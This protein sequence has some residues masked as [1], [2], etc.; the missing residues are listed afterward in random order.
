M[1][2]RLYLRPLFP[3]PLSLLELGVRTD[4]YSL[5]SRKTASALEEETAE[6]HALLSITESNIS[7]N[8]KQHQAWS[9][10]VSHNNIILIRC[11]R[12][13]ERDYGRTTSQETHGAQ[14]DT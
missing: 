10:L 14:S 9:S 1:S 13:K 3:T 12:E 5:D 7:F 4:P 2:Q 11:V 8:K 6:N